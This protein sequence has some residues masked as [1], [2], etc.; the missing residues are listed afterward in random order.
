M[1][2]KM[3]STGW[4][5]ETGR[6]SAELGSGHWVLRAGMDP[7]WRESDS[8]WLEHWDKKEMRKGYRL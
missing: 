2:G 7:P 5:R 4:G 8:V 3:R 6:S 1:C